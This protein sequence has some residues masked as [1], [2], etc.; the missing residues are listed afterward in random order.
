MCTTC[1][2]QTVFSNSSYSQVKPAIYVFNKEY[3]AVSWAVCFSDLNIVQ[4]DKTILVDP[5]DKKPTF[6]LKY[7]DSDEACSAELNTPVLGGMVTP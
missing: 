7:E 4:T 6:L 5:Q 2:R 1:G 3:P